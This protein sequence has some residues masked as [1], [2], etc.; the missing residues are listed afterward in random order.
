MAAAAGPRVGGF[1]GLPVIFD[2]YH[3][4]ST[5]YNVFRPAI[6]PYPFTWDTPQNHR[7]TSFP[8]SPSRSTSSI[9]FRQSL[10]PSRLLR[11]QRSRCTLLLPTLRTPHSPSHILEP[12]IP[13]A[14]STQSLRLG[15]P[16]MAACRALEDQR[17]LTELI[18]EFLDMRSARHAANC[19]D[20]SQMRPSS[21]STAATL[22]KEIS[23]RRSARSPRK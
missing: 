6:A 14:Q 20:T 3:Q 12:S 10:L 8:A 23:R 18:A 17:V 9:L 22:Y 7:K 1:L 19:C 16:F 13:A 21:N 4:Y 11:Q 2:T 5:V 15:R